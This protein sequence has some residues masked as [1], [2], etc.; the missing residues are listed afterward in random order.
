M[1]RSVAKFVIVACALACPSA[2]FAHTGIGGTSGFVHGFAHPIGGLDH[3]LAMV[4]AGTLAWQLGGRTLYAVPASFVLL[5]AVGG[6]LGVAGIDVP[7][8]ETGIALSIVAFGVAVA[9]GVKAPTALAMA[10]VGLFAIFHGHAHGAE[11]PA[12]ASGLGY[13][14]GFMLATALLH[15][16]GIG[17]GFLLGRAGERSGGL[18]VRASGAAAAAIGFAFLTGV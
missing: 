14:L 3:V 8:V 9:A 2:A 16:A 11:M 18:L 7:L 13:G 6:G 1:N 15:A 5:M 4:L 12:D 10:F 17:A